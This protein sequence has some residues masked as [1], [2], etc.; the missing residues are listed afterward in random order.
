MISLLRSDSR[1]RQWI[2]PFE[3]SRVYG[4]PPWFAIGPVFDRFEHLAGVT[5]SVGSHCLAFHR[6]VH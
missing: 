5:V 4:T 3:M 6:A 2:T 1:I